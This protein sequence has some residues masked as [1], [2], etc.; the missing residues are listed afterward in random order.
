[1]RQVEVSALASALRP[2]RFPILL[3]GAMIALFLLLPIALVVVTSFSSSTFLIFPPSGFSTRWYR[4][5]VD[6]PAWMGALKTS[7]IVAVLAATC[8][9]ALG[10]AAALAVRRLRRGAGL[11]RGLFLAPLIIPQIV[12]AVGL[13]FVFQR[14]GVFGARWTVVVGQAAVALPLVLLTVSAGIAGIDP[15]VFRAAENLG[16]RWPRITLRIEL[17]LLRRSIFFAFVVALTFCFDEA[18]IALFLVP[19]GE[20]TFPVH[21]WLSARESV[22]PAV[23]AASSLVMAITIAVTAVGAWTVT[24][25]GAGGAR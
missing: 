25:R 15:A 19:P 18:V 10:T 14:L 9:T 8:A 22:S 4:E 16:A 1:M 6:D 11:F 13:Y 2:A 12:F 24:R 3:A 7:A 5:V 20:E 21:L 23:A 17:P